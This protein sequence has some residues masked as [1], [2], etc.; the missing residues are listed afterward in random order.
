[1]IVDCIM[2]SNIWRALGNSTIIHGH[3]FIFSLFFLNVSSKL[4][5]IVAHSSLPDFLP[6]WLAGRITWEESESLVLGI[7]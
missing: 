7:G 1:M 3:E 6:I 5:N 4:E 2:L